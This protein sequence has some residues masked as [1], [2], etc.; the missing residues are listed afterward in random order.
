MKDFFRTAIMWS[1]VWPLL[2]PLMVILIHN[3]RGKEIRPVILYVLLALL[4]NLTA[5]LVSI[6]RARLPDWMQSNNIL[7]NVHSF[8]RVLLFGWYFTRLNLL[9]PVWFPKLLFAAYGLYVIINFVLIESVWILSS[10]L[11]AA[12][13]IILLTFGITYFSS[14]I[15]DESDRNWLKHPSFL[16]CTAVCFY[17]AITFFIFLF[18][19]P[20]SEST[21]QF[22]ILTMRIYAV[23][24]MLFCILLALALYREKKWTANNAAYV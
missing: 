6:Y 18:Y 21:P 15:R 23:C 9:R 3:I 16:I 11:F 17:K 5:N 12:E 24:F 19:Y 2:I 20:V 14:S 1:E 7:Y 10:G 13:S 4:L 22:G 8:I